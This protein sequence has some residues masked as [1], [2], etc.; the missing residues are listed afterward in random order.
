MRKSLLGVVGMASLLLLSCDDE[1]KGGGG[2]CGNF[3]PCGGDVVGTWNIK[4]YCLSNTASPI[5]ECPA[6]TVSVDG[7]SASGTVTYAAN[8]TTTANTTIRGTMKMNIPASCLM[9]ATCALVDASLKSELSDPESPFSSAS[10]TG[11]DT[12]SCSLVLKGTPMTSSGT[13]TISGNQLI[14][15]GDA[16]EYCVSG[17]ELRLKSPMSMAGMMEDLAF[18]AVLEKQ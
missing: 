14:E 18:S 5:P 2:S 1:D 9:G 3:T 15:D 6:A 4:Q 8:M 13:Y 16:N 10:C 7:L 17:K 11:S 12:C